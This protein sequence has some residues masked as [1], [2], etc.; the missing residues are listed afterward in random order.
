MRNRRKYSCEPVKYLLALLAK[1]RGSAFFLG[2]QTCD[3]CRATSAAERGFQTRS[4]NRRTCHWKEGLS[5]GLDGHLLA[6]HTSVFHL[7]LAV[8]NIETCFLLNMWFHWGAPAFIVI[9]LF[10]FPFWF[11]FFPVL[12]GETGFHY[13]SGMHAQSSYVPANKIK[14]PFNFI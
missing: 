7:L 2:M 3:L 5:G 14:S 4:G 13:F 6:N 8:G 10:F 11:F 9:I 12:M 1:V